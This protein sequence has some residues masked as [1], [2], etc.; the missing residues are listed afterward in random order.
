[1]QKTAGNFVSKLGKHLDSEVTAS[2]E[3]SSA[4]AAQP[5]TLAGSSERGACARAPASTLSPRM[6]DKHAKGVIRRAAAQRYMY[7][8]EGEKTLISPRLLRFHPLNRDG[9][10]CNGDRCGELL[11]NF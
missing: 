3:H 9:I 1:M 6:G 5:P 10:A 7:N 4:L 2:P 11:G 8:P